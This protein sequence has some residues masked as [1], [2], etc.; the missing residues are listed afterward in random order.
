MLEEPNLFSAY[1]PVRLDQAISSQY[2]ARKSRTPQAGREESTQVYLPQATIIHYI[3][4]TTAARHRGLQ[5][6]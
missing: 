2:K 5:R 3:D 6:K 4:H 1:P